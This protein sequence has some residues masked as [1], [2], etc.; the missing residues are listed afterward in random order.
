MENNDGWEEIG[1][2]RAIWKYSGNTFPIAIQVKFIA[3][4]AFFRTRDGLSIGLLESPQKF[5][6]YN[7]SF[8]AETSTQLLAIPEGIIKQFNS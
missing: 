7:F 6:N 5:S 2:V 8:T 3:G 1:A 4:K